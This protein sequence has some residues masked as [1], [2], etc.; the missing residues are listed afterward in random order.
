MTRLV[1]RLDALGDVVLAGPA[2]RAAAAG[3][4]PVAVLCSPT[5]APAARLLP[6][7]GVVVEY[8]A[9]WI[10]ADAPVHDRRRWDATVASVR[11]LEVD[12]ALV[13]TS[14]HQSALPTALLLREAGVGR[15]TAYSEDYPGS[16]VDD[17]VAP[18]GDVHEVE[19][20]LHL[21]SVAGWALPAGD[22]GRLRLRAPSPPRSSTGVVVHPGA[23]APARTLDPDVWADVV[24]AL[25]ERGRRVTV[26]GGA[27]EA[28]LVDRVAGAS[29]DRLVGAPLPVLVD[30]LARAATVVTGNTGPLHLAAAV[31]TPVVCA[32][33]PTVPLARWGPWGVDHKVL[34][35]QAVA[36][37]GC[38][39]R[40]CPL[41]PRPCVGGVDADAV[42]EAIDELAPAVAA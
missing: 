17:R 35:R 13:L 10:A 5:G 30:T 29:A 7:V 20:A 22:D 40:R 26:T 2:V 41:S 18:L 36:C 1:V 19:R 8:E 4:G 12:H 9:P 23:S 14:F 11:A 28:G 27:A 6:G 34:G 39:L 15:V 33:P 21:A 37:A 16:L 38:R 25:V 42:V 3:H 31:A 32:F 24:R